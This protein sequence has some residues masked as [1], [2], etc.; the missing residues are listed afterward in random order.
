MGKEKEEK[1]QAREI[2]YIAA[3]EDAPGNVLIMKV[4]TQHGEV[5]VRSAR[6]RGQFAKGIEPAEEDKTTESTPQ[7]RYNGVVSKT[8]TPGPQGCKSGAKEPQANIGPKD[9]PPCPVE[10]SPPP[11][12]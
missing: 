1:Y 4:H 8:T 3:V 5:I 10:R 2:K 12:F 6:K 9:A 7:E 11:G